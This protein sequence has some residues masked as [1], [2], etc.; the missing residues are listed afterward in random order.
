MPRWT[1][2]L[3]YLVWYA[4]HG[5]LY[6]RVPTTVRHGFRL[7]WRNSVL[8]L[9]ATKWH[10]GEFPYMGWMVLGK[11]L[12]AALDR[13]KLTLENNIVSRT[14]KI[15]LH[16]SALIHELK[17]SWCWFLKL[18]HGA[19]VGAIEWN[20]LV[21]EES[22]CTWLLFTISS[23]K[24]PS[25]I[26]HALVAFYQDRAFGDGGLSDGRWLVDRTTKIITSYLAPPNPASLEITAG[27]WVVAKH[28]YRL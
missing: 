13:S 19:V 8:W 23:I 20:S 25:R 18:P 14:W 28:D 21:L 9:T 6:R 27:G 17:N 10:Q 5:W 3:P 16:D 26:S 2:F 22:N 24:H 12:F 4:V 1:I 7:A 15:Y 11:E